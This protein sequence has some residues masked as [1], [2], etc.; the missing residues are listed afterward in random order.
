[1][2]EL[3]RTRPSTST[4]DIHGEERYER[5]NQISA[6]KTSPT[7]TE[8]FKCDLCEFS[9]NHYKDFL[10]HLR[11]HAGAL[12]KGRKIYGQPERPSELS[13]NFASKDIHIYKCTICNAIFSI[14]D[15]FVKHKENCAPALDNG[16]SEQTNKP[17]IELQFK[18]PSKTAQRKNIRNYECEGCHAKFGYPPCLREHQKRCKHIAIRDPPKQEDVIQ[19]PPNDA[20]DTGS[21]ESVNDRPSGNEYQPH[22]EFIQ[23]MKV[24]YM[25]YVC[26]DCV[27][28]SWHGNE[29]RSTHVNSTLSNG[30]ASQI[31]SVNHSALASAI[32]HPALSNVFLAL[33]YRLSV[34]IIHLVPPLSYQARRPPLIQKSRQRRQERG[35]EG[36]NGQSRQNWA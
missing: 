24:Q 8:T 7:L 31:C 32:I 35:K 11:K 36:K 5:K 15:N 2:D 17:E 22:S 33:L 1:M 27:W 18:P 9:N 4:T 26:S 3:D 13:I 29:E 10:R 20:D 19:P 14:H 34:S 28:R 21:Y 6:H 16:V 30:I 25:I 12:R 23:Q